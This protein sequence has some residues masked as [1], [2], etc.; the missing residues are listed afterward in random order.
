MISPAAANSG[1]PQLHNYDFSNF[2]DPP[3]LQF[4]AFYEEQ[5][6]G[7][8]EE[9]EEEENIEE[10]QPMFGSVAEVLNNE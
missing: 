5:D 1:C 3:P 4:D 6:Y 9:E 7:M 8:E 2:Y 10:M